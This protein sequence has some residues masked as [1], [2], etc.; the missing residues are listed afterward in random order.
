MLVAPC[1]AAN[2]AA[3]RHWGYAVIGTQADLLFSGCDSLAN[4]G[5]HISRQF[6][7]MVALS[8]GAGAV[9]NLVCVVPFPII[10]SEV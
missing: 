9:P 8:V 1:L 6:R 4:L 3:Y 7:H 10:P 2:Y 5:N